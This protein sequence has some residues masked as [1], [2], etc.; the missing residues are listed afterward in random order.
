MRSALHYAAMAGY[1]K[2]AETLIENGANINLADKKA[3]PLFIMP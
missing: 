1:F 3:K 2:L